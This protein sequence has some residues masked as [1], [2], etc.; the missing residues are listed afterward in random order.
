V[1]LSPLFF[2]ITQKSIKHLLVHVKIKVGVGQSVV[3]L[4]F[5]LR[6][7]D[8]TLRFDRCRENIY[9]K[10]VASANLS[11]GSCG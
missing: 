4:S 8:E 9:E 3:L 11:C 2:H 5:S 1:P 7:C 6:L 10:G